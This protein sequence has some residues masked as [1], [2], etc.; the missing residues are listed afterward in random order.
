V[1]VFDAIEGKEELVVSWLAG[2]QQILYTEELA[3]PNDRQYALM[4]VSPGKS[5]QLV[6]GFEGY[7]NTGGPTERDQPFQPVVATLPRHGDMVKLPGT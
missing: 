6:T 4:R 7:A 3:F 2:S 1:W 5:G